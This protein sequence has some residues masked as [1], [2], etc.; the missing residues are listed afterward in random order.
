MEKTIE[1]RAVIR[2]YWRACF[3]ATKTFE[4]IQKVYGESAV[5]R[6][7]VFRWYNTFS[8]GRESI[9]DEQKSR[10]PTCSWYF[11]GRLSV[12][13]YTHRRTNGNTKNYRAT[14]SVRR[15]T[16]MVVCSHALKA[17]QKEQRFTHTYDLTETIKSN[18]NFLKYIIT[19]NEIWCFAYDPETQRQSSKWWPP[20]KKFWFQKSRVN[21][22]PYS[23]CRLS[24]SHLNLYTEWKRTCYKNIGIIGPVY[25]SSVKLTFLY[26]ISF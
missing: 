6:A 12:F 20:S 8:E 9:R 17:K 15:F 23:N 13:V 16:E 26:I 7:T 22:R 2:F 3:N 5:H 10:R 21:H 4:M 19:D 24:I 25:L 11:E 18:Q 1:Q 14:S